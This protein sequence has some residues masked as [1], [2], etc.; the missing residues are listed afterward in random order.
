MS[1]ILADPA[2]EG[3]QDR[4]SPDAALGLL[5]APSDSTGRRYIIPKTILVDAT[6]APVTIGSGGGSG[7]QFAQS[8]V[9][10]DAINANATTGTV[11]SVGDTLARVIEATPGSPDTL[12]ARWYNITKDTQLT[13]SPTMADLVEQNNAGALPTAV[14]QD[15]GGIGMLGALGAI[16]TRLKTYTLADTFASVA[17]IATM[18]FGMLWNGTN[19][20]RWKGDSTGAARVSLYGKTSTAGDTALRVTAAG[21][22]VSTGG[23]TSSVN[24][25]AS[26]TTVATLASNANRL[27]WVVTNDTA[28]IMYVKIGAS[29]TTS[30]Y[31]YALSPKTATSA[32]GSCEGTDTCA[33][34]FILPSSTGNAMVTEITA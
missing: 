29:A 21:L 8:T 32:G 16:I 25:V 14:S 23:A 6:G 24:A 34:S 33:I 1:Q 13:G 15:T 12:V 7:S 5:Y 2:A 27:K 22:A 31:T 11:Y 28:V 9:Y 20:D 10:Y 3:G 30:S 18:N 4:G 17:S 26:S 19:W